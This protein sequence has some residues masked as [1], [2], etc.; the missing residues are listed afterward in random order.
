ME[1][2]TET[3]KIREDSGRNPEV[4]FENYHDLGFDVPGLAGLSLTS[5]RNQ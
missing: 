4:L 5:L 3:E 1:H 2:L